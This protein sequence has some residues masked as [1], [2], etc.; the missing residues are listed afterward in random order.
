MSKEKEILEKKINLWIKKFVNSL[1]YKL[2]DIIIIQLYIYFELLIFIY[3]FY[4]SP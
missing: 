3:I 1:N 4:V 2:I